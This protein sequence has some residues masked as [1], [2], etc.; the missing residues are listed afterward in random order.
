MTDTVTELQKRV[1]II[2][3]QASGDDYYTFTLAADEVLRRRIAN[4]RGSA[5]I[6]LFQPGEAML[7]Y[8]PLALFRALWRANDSFEARRNILDAL[9]HACPNTTAAAFPAV[10]L[11]DVRS[12]DE[13]DRV[14]AQMSPTDGNA[15][16]GAV[17]RKL[18]AESHVFTSEDLGRL[19]QVANVLGSRGAGYAAQ[20]TRIIDRIDYLRLRH[21]LL[22]ADWNP[23]INADQVALIERATFLG[24]GEDLAAGLREL[25]R[26]IG[27]AVN[28]FDFKSCMDLVRTTL[29]ELYKQAAAKAAERTLRPAPSGDKVGHHRDWLNYL[30]ENGVVSRDESEFLQKFYNYLSNEGAHALGSA[31]EQ[32]RV[33]RNTAVE[34]M[35]L[36]SGRIKTLIES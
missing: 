21:E 16:L 31:P 32:V 23:E 4:G 10:V 5:P 29:E 11:L 12:Y 7:T 36:I 9:E 30:R 13:I 27:A 22:Q 17:T 1:R 6:E 34:W 14:V 18:E 20:T 19:R 2:V 3:S 28:S 25:D 8:E 33:S 35:F 15:F 26:R 24:F